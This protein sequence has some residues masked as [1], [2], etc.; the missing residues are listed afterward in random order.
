M[1]AECICVL[2]FVCRM[3]AVAFLYIINQLIF[4]TEIRRVLST[5][6]LIFIPFLSSFISP[7][8]IV[9][10]NPLSFLPHFYF[11]LFFCFPPSLCHLFCILSILHSTHFPDYFLL[12]CLSLFTFLCFISTCFES[13]KFPLSRFLL[14]F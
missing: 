13:P 9:L 8:C 5:L 10:L 1:I 3:K 2:R 4:V 6:I 14:N 7:S 12:L 11:T